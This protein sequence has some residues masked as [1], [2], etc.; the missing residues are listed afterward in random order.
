MMVPKMREKEGEGFLSIASFHEASNLA[1]PLSN[2]ANQVGPL[3]AMIF[4]VQEA[5]GE[6]FN[7]HTMALAKQL[8]FA[9]AS[10]M[11]RETL[12]RFTAK[13]WSDCGHDL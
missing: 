7:A 2:P 4:I 3:E 12:W 6:L 8:W 9:L 11:V 5:V 10:T 13:H 1:S